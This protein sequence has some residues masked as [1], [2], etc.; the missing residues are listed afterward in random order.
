[1]NLYFIFRCFFFV[2][3]F[4]VGIGYIKADAMKERKSNDAFATTITNGFFVILCCSLLKE[5]HGQE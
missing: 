2:L 5:E 4:W 1:V 3:I